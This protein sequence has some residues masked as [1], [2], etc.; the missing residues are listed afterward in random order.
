MENL[1]YTDQDGRTRVMGANKYNVERIAWEME[2]TALGNA[3][4]GNALRVA[5]DIPSLSD[6]DLS[7]L[8]R[9]AT[10][11]NSGTDH[12]SLQR[13]ACRLESITK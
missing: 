6:E 10:G 5:K 1:E 12:V 11:L 9:F 2:Q 7:L 3:F 8:D 13:L 4:Y